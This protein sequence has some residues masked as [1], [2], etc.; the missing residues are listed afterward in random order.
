M[1]SRDLIHAL[2]GQIEIKSKLNEGTS[3]IIKLQTHSLVSKSDYDSMKK[4]TGDN[5]HWITRNSKQSSLL[6]TP[7][8]KD[9]LDL[10][11]HHKSNESLLDGDLL[12]DGSESFTPS[13]SD[14]SVAQKNEDKQKRK[15]SKRVKRNC[16]IA[17]DNPFLL[18]TF[19]EVIKSQFDQVVCASDG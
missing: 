12:F 19:K 15:S 1:I 4:N 2:G 14:Q 5:D 3:F 6:Q 16:L 10:S 18:A 8:A 13:E 17:N 11:M 9:K 7:L